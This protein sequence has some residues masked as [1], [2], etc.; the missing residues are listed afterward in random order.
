MMAGGRP[1]HPTPTPGVS[2]TAKEQWELFAYKELRDK[3]PPPTSSDVPHS[4][5]TGEE[6]PHCSICLGEYEEG[7]QLCRLPC[8]HV[9]HTDCINSWCSNHTRCPLCN[10]D[11][12]G[13][14]NSNS[15]ESTSAEEQV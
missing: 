6:A 8:S 7:E 3:Q 4:Y 10:V 9:Y 11:L 12:D 14:A 15:S 5:G 13:T 1:D 2:D